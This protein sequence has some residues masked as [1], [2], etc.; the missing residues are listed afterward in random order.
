MGN[1]CAGSATL[2]ARIMR[3]GTAA[4]ALLLGD[5]PWQRR[6]RARP[7]ASSRAR[8]RKR[9]VVAAARDRARRTRGAMRAALAGA[10]GAAHRV[11]DARAV[12]RARRAVARVALRSS[13]SAGDGADESAISPPA[14][15]AARARGRVPV[16][17]GSAELASRAGRSAAV[18]SQTSH[19]GRLDNRRARGARAAAGR[20]ARPRRRSRM[21][22]STSCARCRRTRSCLSARMNKTSARPTC[23]TCSA[24][25]PD[26][27]VVLAVPMLSF[28]W[29][30]DRIAA[31][32][33]A[34]TAGQPLVAIV[35]RLLQARR[36]VFAD[37]LFGQVC[38]RRSRAIRTAK[39]FASPRRA[40]SPPSLD[41][42]IMAESRC[43]NISRSTSRGPDRTTVIRRSRI[44]ACC[45]DGWSS[46]RICAGR[47]YWQR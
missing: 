8:W 31:R 29:Y 30:R 15:A 18:G 33:V 40:I 43:S 34:I 46:S 5:R 23:R 24:S 32:G 7:V 41:D 44:T 3:R 17:I 37:I 9:L 26:V 36:P 35:G 19:R 6:Y 39:C 14:V 47:R 28:P 42:V 38:S 11:V 1:P 4:S 25:R 13:R 20:G 21:A 27:E 45:A 10:C 16:S 12:V 22:S 2:V